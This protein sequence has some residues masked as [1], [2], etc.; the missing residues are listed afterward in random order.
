MRVEVGAELDVAALYRTVRVGMRLSMF[1]SG[2]LAVA[3][4]AHVSMEDVDSK[5]RRLSQCLSF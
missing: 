4:N 5:T 2:Q 1:L 3:F